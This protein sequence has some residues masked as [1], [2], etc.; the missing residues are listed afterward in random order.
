M[1]LINVQLA[2]SSELEALAQTL[3]RA[4]YDDP[5]YRWLL[6]DAAT[7][8][9][10]SSRIF[11][12]FLRQELPRGTVYT[13]PGLHAVAVW[14]DMVHGR[15][16]VWSELQM[17]IPMLGLLG[18]GIW[19]GLRYSLQVDTKHPRYP[20]RYL[21]FLGTAPQGQ[22]RGYGSALLQHGLQI[23]QAQNVPAF[24]E[25]SSEPNLAFYRQRGFRL[26]DEIEIRG[27]PRMYRMLWRA[28]R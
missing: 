25:T 3:A 12:L 22:G 20:H 26:F 18:K 28:S 1:P 2:H 14:M 7:R 13:V 16:S 17:T 24:L 19:R 8:T 9:E 15:P 21:L 23:C 5:V 6:P 27:G 4:F 11:S 10:K